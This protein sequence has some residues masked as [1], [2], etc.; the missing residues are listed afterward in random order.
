MRAE[1]E[2]LLLRYRREGNGPPNSYSGNTNMPILFVIANILTPQ[3]YKI[4]TLFYFRLRQGRIVGG[5]YGDHPK[6][7]KSA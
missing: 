4:S 5:G 3:E 6:T 1:I 2:G 7:S